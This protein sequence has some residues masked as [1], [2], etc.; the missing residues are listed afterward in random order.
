M[1]GQETTLNKA[2]VILAQPSEAFKS[3]PALGVGTMPAH[4]CPIL[5]PSLFKIRSG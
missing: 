3:P 5:T 4:P 1:P 2:G